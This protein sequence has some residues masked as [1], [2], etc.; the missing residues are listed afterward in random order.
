[1]LN[2]WY[3]ELERNK[4]IR[5]ILLDYS[6]AFDCVDHTLLLSKLKSLEVPNILLRWIGN[7]LTD[8]QQ[9]V[10]INNT[11]SEWLK[12]NGSVPQGSCLGPL[13]FVIMIDDLVTSDPSKLSKYMDDAT[14]SESFIKPSESVM[15]QSV[16]EIS[17]WSKDN[18]L[19]PNPTKTKEM[20]IKFTQS[21]LQLNPILLNDLEIERVDKSKLLGIIINNKL[22]WNDHVEYIYTKA[23]KRLYFLTMLRRSGSDKE[24]LKMYYTSV[25]RSVLEFSC[26]VWSTGL[27]IGEQDKLESIQKRAFKIITQNEDYEVAKHELNLPTL[28]ERRNSL[29]KKLF[30]E[31]QRNDH[32]LHHLLPPTRDIPIELRKPFKYQVPHIRTERLKKSFLYHCLLNYQ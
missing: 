30:T 14:A 12:I 3:E 23:C 15:Q 22:T 8:R 10:K 31:M 5:A 1:M 20:I 4:T 18:N 27:T 25:I 9:R 17:A 24:D 32:K 26:Q 16:N 2:H 21:E 7:F 29:C 13:L 19:N 6:K 28:E 11:V